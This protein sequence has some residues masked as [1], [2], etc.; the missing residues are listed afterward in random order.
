MT[1]LNG[2]PISE[3]QCI[4]DSLQFINSAFITLSTALAV[5]IGTAAPAFAP[6]YIGQEFLNKTTTKFYKAS[7][8]NANDWVILN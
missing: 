2:I 3:E 4:G 6:T 1:P 5:T 8:F 7:G